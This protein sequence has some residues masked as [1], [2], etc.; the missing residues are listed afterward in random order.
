[1]C[2]NYSSLN[3]PYPLLDGGD[4]E[5]E[6]DEPSLANV[7]GNEITVCTDDFEEGDEFTLEVEF[8]SNPAPQKV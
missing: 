5:V 4:C 6:E 3:Y 1:M 8:E 7:R 2:T